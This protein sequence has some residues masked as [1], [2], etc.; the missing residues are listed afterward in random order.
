MALPSGGAMNPGIGA[1]AARS[2]ISTSSPAS[3][4]PDLRTRRDYVPLAGSG[5]GS[6]LT[7]KLIAGGAGA[8]QRTKLCD[9]LGRWRVSQVVRQRSAKPPPRVRIPHSPPAFPI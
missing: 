9:W 7:N 4:N 3:G 6:R 2:D 1:Q 5:Q 8:N